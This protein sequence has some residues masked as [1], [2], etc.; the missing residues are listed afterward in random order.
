MALR[1]AV[2]LG[3]TLLSWQSL[4]RE[5]ETGAAPLWL[6]IASGAGAGVCAFLLQTRRT[7]THAS[8]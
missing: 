5:I 3:L 2:I 4:A 1:D 8:S 6:S 7:T